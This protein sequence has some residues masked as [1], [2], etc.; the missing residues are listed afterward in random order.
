[1]RARLTSAQVKT[2]NALIEH[3]TSGLPPTR[4]PRVEEHMGVGISRQ[5]VEPDVK[6]GRAPR[7]KEMRREVDETID[8]LNNATAEVHAEMRSM[9]SKFARV[10]AIDNAVDTERDT[11]AWLQ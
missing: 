7:Q 10:R 11:D 4:H 6:P 1:M 5:A 3:G 9:R 8:R 2:G